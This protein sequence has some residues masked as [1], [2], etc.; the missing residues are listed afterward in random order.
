MRCALASI[1]STFLSFYIDELVLRLPSALGKSVTIVG[2]VHPKPGED[3]H[4]TF[5]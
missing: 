2:A 5:S 3:S 1:E 4:G